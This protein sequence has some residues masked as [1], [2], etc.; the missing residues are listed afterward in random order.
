MANIRTVLVTGAAGGIGRSVCAALLRNGFLVRALIRPEDDPISIPDDGTSLIRGYVQDASCVH[1]AI[2]GADAVV[3]CA[4]ILP[5]APGVSPEQYLEVNLDGT[6]TV[7]RAASDCQLKAA[8]F[9]STISV[10]DHNSKIIDRGKIC[11]YV[12]SALESYLV[13]KIAGERR[14]L[15]AR[16]SFPGHLAVIR[17]GFVYSPNV[18]GVWRKPLQLTAK[19]QMFLIDG[20]SV[21]LPLAYADDVAAYV[22][23]LLRHEK[24]FEPPYDIHVVANPEPTTF[25]DVFTFIADYIDAPRPRNV[26]L[27][28]LKIG[29]AVCEAL[30]LVLRRGPLAML[31]RARVEQYSKGYNLAGVFDHPLLAQVKFTS[32]RVGLSRMLDSYLARTEGC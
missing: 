30:P 5:D 19:G 14:V 23:A 25:S 13:S 24:R 21:G 20:G 27:W 28:P 3:H 11:D 4:A 9:F 8:I 12:T 16:E 2:N 1:R 10:V 22:V 31:T 32:Y 26:P 18:M 29:A 6:A 7:L 15:S 17:P